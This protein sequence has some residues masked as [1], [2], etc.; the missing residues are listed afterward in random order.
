M[1]KVVF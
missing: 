1:E